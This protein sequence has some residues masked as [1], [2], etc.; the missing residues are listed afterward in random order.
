MIRARISYP[1]WWAMHAA[2]HVLFGPDD[3]ELLKWSEPRVL[4]I[5]S[6]GKCPWPWRGLS[7]RVFVRFNVSFF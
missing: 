3:P 1:H 7:F 2:A 4:R 6:E 5:L